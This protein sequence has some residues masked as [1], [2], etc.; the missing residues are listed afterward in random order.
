MLATPARTRRLAIESKATGSRLIALK[1]AMLRGIAPK[2]AA[3]VAPTIR[4]SARTDGHALR[5]L[6]G[7]VA[8]SVSVSLSNPI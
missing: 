7:A 6:H 5:C 4:K 2:S 8:P 3:S 1:R